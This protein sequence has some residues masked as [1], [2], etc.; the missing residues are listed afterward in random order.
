MACAGLIVPTERILYLRIQIRY[1]ST[2]LDIF[3]IKF[4]VKI[5]DI[6]KFAALNDFNFVNVFGCEEYG[7]KN[8]IDIYPRMTKVR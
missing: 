5:T 4:P 3:V 2:V 7:E 1:F 6:Y 8:P